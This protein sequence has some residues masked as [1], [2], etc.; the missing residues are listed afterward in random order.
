[1]NSK[2]QIGVNLKIN[3]KYPIQGS[4]FRDLG[5]YSKTNSGCNL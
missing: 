5:F 3:K 1:M 4:G 2:T